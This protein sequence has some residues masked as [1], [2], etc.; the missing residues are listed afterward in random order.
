MKN[1]VRIRAVGAGGAVV[2]VKASDGKVYSCSVTVN[3]SNESEENKEKNTATQAPNTKCREYSD[4]QW[5]E[6]SQGSPK[7]AFNNAGDHWRVVSYECVK[8]HETKEEGGQPEKCHL[9]DFVVQ[10]P[11]CDKDGKKS[12]KC[13]VCGAEVAYPA[14][15]NT[16]SGWQ[17]PSLIPK[18]G[19]DLEYT[20]KKQVTVRDDW[21][22]N[23]DYNNEHGWEGMGERTATCKTCGESFEEVGF[24]TG[25]ELADGSQA[26]VW[27]V[28]EKGATEILTNEINKYRKGSVDEETGEELDPIIPTEELSSYAL[29]KGAQLRA[30]ALDCVGQQGKGWATMAGFVMTAPVGEKINLVEAFMSHGSSFAYSDLKYSGAAHLRYETEDGGFADTV[31]VVGD[32]DDHPRITCKKAG[33]DEDYAGICHRCGRNSGLTDDDWHQEYWS[34]PYLGSGGWVHVGVPPR[35]DHEGFTY[36]PGGFD[37]DHDGICDGC[38]GPLLLRAG[39]ASWNYCNLALFGYGGMDFNNY[40]DGCFEQPNVKEK[41]LSYV[42]NGKRIESEENGK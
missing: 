4:H 14:D 23:Y 22:L 36:D 38:G 42:A 24:D 21:D 3:G 37:T 13:T 19:H 12:R 32:M 33:H 20:Y 6:V 7:Y 2:S 28:W 8:C 11:T 31:I 35:N 30:R 26:V 15:Y 39:V 25:V 18:T 40:H 16:P 10:A 34:D 41:L 1:A 9:V 17:R 5:R 27:G 29:F